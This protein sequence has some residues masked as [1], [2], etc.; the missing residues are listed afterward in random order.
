MDTP[1]DTISTS[2]STSTSKKKESRKFS[3]DE[4]AKL[5]NETM[6][7]QFSRV[8]IPLNN[9][10]KNKFRPALTE[11]PN[12]DW[13]K[14][15]FEK[16][17][18]IPGLSGENDRGWRADLEFVVKNRTKIV[19]GKYDTWGKTQQKTTPPPIKSKP[20]WQGATCP[21]Q[22]KPAECPICR[23]NASATTIGGK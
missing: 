17:S 10:R 13:W 11:F 14:N 21:H 22:A 18:S 4:L 6:P 2:T 15:I 5:W 16:V 9:G 1:R 23:Q 20:A 12:I 7:A 8:T 19:E 3:P